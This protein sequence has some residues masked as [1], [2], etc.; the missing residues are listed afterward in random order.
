MAT[1]NEAGTV[2]INTAFFC[3]SRDL[4]LYFLSHPESVHCHNLTRVPRMAAA[5]FDSHQPWGDPHAGLQLFG[6]GVLIHGDTARQARELYAA[7][8]PRYRDF[9]RRAPGED[10]TASTFGAL[11][12]YRLLPERLQ[13]LDEGSSVTRCSSRPPSCRRSLV[14][15]RDHE[16]RLF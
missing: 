14:P 3:F 9:L 15:H 12:L 5:V 6:N 10:P 11:Q 13:I 2:H 16:H 1:R 8:F 7:R 4:A